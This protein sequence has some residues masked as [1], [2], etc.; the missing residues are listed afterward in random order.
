MTATPPIPMNASLPVD[1]ACGDGFLQ[2][3][4]ESCDDGNSSDNDA[5][6]STC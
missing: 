4:V 2:D 1:A 3:G 6:L 5:R